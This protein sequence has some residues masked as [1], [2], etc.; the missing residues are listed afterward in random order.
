MKQLGDGNY[1]SHHIA[2]FGHD[3]GKTLFFENVPLRS[4]RDSS[5]QMRKAD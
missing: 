1:E 3:T 5:V 2:R 4:K